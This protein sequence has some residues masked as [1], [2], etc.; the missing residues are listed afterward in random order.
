[1]TQR[2]IASGGS[3]RVTWEVTEGGWLAVAACLRC[4]ESAFPIDG[5]CSRY[6]RE[7]DEYD[8][9]N[10]FNAPAIE[11]LGPVTPEETSAAWAE[12]AKEA[13][14]S[15]EDAWSTAWN[16]RFYFEAPK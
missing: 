12:W 6:C 7:C 3:G 14:G 5:Y 10:N 11:A 9:E 16:D 8:A 15:L 2:V 13:Y 4:G 1:V